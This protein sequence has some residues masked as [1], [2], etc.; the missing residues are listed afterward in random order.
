MTKDTNKEICK[1]LTLLRALQKIDVEFPL[2]YAIC[3]A[4]ISLDEGLSLTQLA[5]RTNMA[6]STVSRIIGAL[7]DARQKGQPFGLIEVQISRQERRRKELYLSPKGR[8]LINTLAGL[9]V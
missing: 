4:E 1:F 3:F 9:M 7:S 8:Q 6:I 2:Q 5:E